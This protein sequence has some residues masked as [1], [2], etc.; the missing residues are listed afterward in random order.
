MP[1]NFTYIKSPE[2]FFAYLKKKGRKSIL[3]KLKK[4]HLPPAPEDSAPKKARKLPAD[5][6]RSS[7]RLKRSAPA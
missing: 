2:E 7:K 3:K 6:S 1:Q 5:A 4:T